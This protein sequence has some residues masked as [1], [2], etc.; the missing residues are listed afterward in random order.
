MARESNKR[1]SVLLSMHP[2]LNPAVAAAAELFTD[3]RATDAV[4]QRIASMHGLPLY[5]VP[6]AAPRPPPSTPRL[7]SG[8]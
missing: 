4:L 1:P 7:L 5:I 3:S 2:R 6:G 8:P